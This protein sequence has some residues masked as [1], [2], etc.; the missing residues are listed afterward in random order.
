MMSL[1]IRLLAVAILIT[2]C[3]VHSYYLEDDR[4]HLRLKDGQAREVLFSSSLEGFGLQGARKTDDTTWEVTVPDKGEFTYF[5]VVDGKVYLPDCQCREK[6]DFG[7][8]NCLY[9]PGKYRF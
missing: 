1:L 3:A 2:G 7:A 9:K 6:D 8:Y 5:Y 4:V